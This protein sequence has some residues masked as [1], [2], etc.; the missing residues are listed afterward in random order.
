[1]SNR[2]ENPGEMLRNC[3]KKKKKKLVFTK[4]VFACLLFSV[5]VLVS[6]FLG[7]FLLFGCDGLRNNISKFYNTPRFSIMII[8]ALIYSG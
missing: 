4:C 6:I 7:C 2:L 5:N 3:F 8:E 1:M